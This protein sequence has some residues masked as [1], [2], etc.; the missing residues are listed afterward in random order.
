M[1]IFCFD[2][3]FLYWWYQYPIFACYS[4][5]KEDKTTLRNAAKSL[6]YPLK[7]VYHLCGDGDFRI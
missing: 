6:D 1:F 3:L 2:D 7:C 4:Q 5:Y